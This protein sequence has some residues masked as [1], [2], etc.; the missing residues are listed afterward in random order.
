MFLDLLDS[1]K[2][3]NFIEVL[4]DYIGE[5]VPRDDYSYQLA[6]ER[7]KIKPFEKLMKF[8]YSIS[9]CNIQWQCDLNTHHEIKKFHPDDTIISGQV[10]IRQIDDM[11]EFDK[12]LEAGWWLYNLEQEEKKDLYNFRYFDFNDDNI[13][14]G[15]ITENNLMKEDQFY[16]ITQKAEGFSPVNMSFDDYIKKWD[17]YKG[18]QGWQQNE[19]FKTTTN[20]KRMIHYLDQLFGDVT[21]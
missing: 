1:L 10:V 4:K 7:F 11:L 12:K 8:Y 20:Y 15:F 2:K 6:L 19:F 9:S 14:V 16:F 17:L 18:Y 3:N 21:K 5:S 13:R